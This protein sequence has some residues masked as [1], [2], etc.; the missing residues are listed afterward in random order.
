MVGTESYKLAVCSS[1]NFSCN[2]AT[3]L[4]SFLL[5]FVAIRDTFIIVAVVLGFF[6]LALLLLLFILAERKENNGVSER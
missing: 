3:Y 4:V 6:F 2:A 1:T 5:L